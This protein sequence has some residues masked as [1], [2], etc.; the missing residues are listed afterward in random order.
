M[1]R[2]IEFF[3]MP[4]AGKSTQISLLQ[5]RLS[6]QYRINVFTDREVPFHAGETWCQFNLRYLDSLDLFVNRFDGDSS[7]VLLFD[8]GYY[9]NHIWPVVHFAMGNYTAADVV[10]CAERLSLSTPHFPD[11]A[12]LFFVSPEVALTRHHERP[13]TADAT[14]ITPDY[15]NELYHQYRRYA[16]RHPDVHVIDGEKPVEEVYQE[17]VSLLRL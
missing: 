5:G 4:G 9:D 2:K 17:V 14:V 8:R 13:H 11:Q 7:G 1:V 3:G 16:E 6:S 12:V 10:A 15:L